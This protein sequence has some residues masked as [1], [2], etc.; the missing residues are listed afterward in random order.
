MSRTPGLLWLMGPLGTICLAE[1][2]FA[3][4]L[5]G[6]CSKAFSSILRHLLTASS[7]GKWHF[8]QCVIQLPFFCNN[9]SHIDNRNE[10]LSHTG[11][12][13]NSGVF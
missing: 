1:G 9:I 13:A 12:L 2:S 6:L 11:S 4:T 7:H 3:V 5:S 10:K 8:C